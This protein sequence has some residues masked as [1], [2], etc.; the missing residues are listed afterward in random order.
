MYGYMRGR[1]RVRNRLLSIDSMLYLRL[2]VTLEVGD[3]GSEWKDGGGGVEDDQLTRRRH[4][5]TFWVTSNIPIHHTFSVDHLSSESDLGYIALISLHIVCPSEYIVVTW[6]A[7]KAIGQRRDGRQRPNDIPQ[8]EP[9]NI[10][11]S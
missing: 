8:G 7:I 11:K 6:I 5:S 10:Q 3:I 9:I 1:R 2:G 4:K